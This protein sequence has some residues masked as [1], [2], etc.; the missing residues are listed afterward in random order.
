[1]FK[2]KFSSI[3]LVIPLTLIFLVCLQAILFYMFTVQT[4]AMGQLLTGRFWWLIVIMVLVAG[5]AAWLLNIVFCQK[6]DA[7]ILAMQALANGD[8]SIRTRMDGQDE[9]SVMGQTFDRMAE[10]L[11]QTYAD[12]QQ[13][14]QTL[15]RSEQRFRL[16][17]ENAQDVIYRFRFSPTLAFDYVSPAITKLSGYTPEEF[18]A[19]PQLIEA[20]LHPEDQE[21]LKLLLQTPL[22]TTEPLVIRWIRKDGTLIWVE[23]RYGLVQDEQGQRVAIEGMARDISKRKQAEDELHRRV[24]QLALLNDISSRIGIAFNVQEVLH[25]AARLV[26]E[27]FGYHHVALFVI[28]QAQDHLIM[29]ARAGAYLEL[30][31]PQ[32]RL[33]SHQ[34][35]VGWVW[36]HGQSL[37]ANDVTLEPNYFNHHPGVMPTQAELTVPI[38]IGN[39]CVGVL[40]IQSPQL[41]AFDENDVM[42]METLAGQIAVAIENTRLLEAAQQELAERKQAEEALRQLNEELEQRVEERTAEVRARNAQYKALLGALPDLML[43]LHRDG[44][45]ID[46]HAPN[47]DLLWAMPE[48][49]LGKNLDHILPGDITAVIMQAIEQAAATGQLQ[50]IEYPFIR[51]NKTSYHEARIV[52]CGPD[53]FLVV[54]RNI[55]E[56]KTSEAALQL[57]KDQLQAILDN[58]SASI[59][60]KDL[61]G[62]Y[63]VANKSFVEMGNL[64]DQPVIGKTDAELFLPDL[65]ETYLLNDQKVVNYNAPLEFEETFNRGQERLTYLTTK[66]PLRDAAGQPYAIGGITTNITARKRIEDALQQ[67]TE[68]L[69]Q[70]N[71]ELAKAARLKDEFLASMSHELRTPLNAILGMTEVLQ[72]QIH[73]PVNEKQARSLHIIEESG[74][75]LLALINDILDLAKIEAE[76]LNLEISP[77]DVEQVCEASLRLVKDTAF[78]KHLEIFTNFEGRGLIVQADERRL[79][80]ILVNLLSNAVKFTPEG[81]KIGLELRTDTVEQ[82]IQF[83]V[84]DTGIGIAANDISRLFKPFVQLDSRLSRQF[85]GT[86]LG[87]SLVQRLS[88]LHGGSITLESTPGQ[89]SRFTVALPWT[90]KDMQKPPEPALNL[91]A[92]LVSSSFTSARGL[93]QPPLI[94]LAED[95]ESNI[96]TM[97]NYLQ[98]KG[99]RLTVA[100]HGAEA[101]ERAKTERPDLII[102]DIQMPG[103]D[104]LTATRQIRASNDSTLAAIPIIALTALAMPGD[105]ERCLAAGANEYLTKPVG[106]RALIGVIEG[107]LK[108]ALPQGATH[109]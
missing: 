77:V 72:D 95:N 22:S 86:G 17:A 23:Q 25:R 84:W 38:H 107:L 36:R 69:S 15:H 83:V 14:E 85:E 44:T 64:S 32:H 28:D 7:L 78:K 48:Q 63:L 61:A 2:I 16:L 51:D 67:R 11:A 21:W 24:A 76:K 50:L 65:A 19:N 90:D 66:F 1:M 109:V 27:S 42:V 3:R 39:S 13:R 104:G 58:S 47:P 31:P 54:E 35:M 92:K 33:K 100:R 34:G 98:A 49:F 101:I 99:Y 94:L 12:L 20:L 4:Q 87:L 103:M 62:R 43:R 102:M 97:G 53:E 70:V 56:R 5:V 37:L 74:R 29:Q 52:D 91:S 80:Q 46:Y 59:F 108:P 6:I 75:H 40:D 93:T 96:S 9:L 8:F 82:V 57:T 106:L 60:V 68:E 89:G 73:G 79:K 55:T 10:R 41:N 30:F 71:A 88:E 81:G 45:L 26:H 105:Q 18:Y